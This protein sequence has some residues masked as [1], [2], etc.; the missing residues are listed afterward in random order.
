[1]RIRRGENVGE[2]SGRKGA[3]KGLRNEVQKGER[4]WLRMR[5]RK[6]GYEGRKKGRSLEEENEEK[7]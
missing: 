5:L 4:T 1:M 7:E 6:F 2:K 3:R